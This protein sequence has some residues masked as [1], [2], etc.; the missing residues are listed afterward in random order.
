MRLMRGK[1]LPTAIASVS[2]EAETQFSHEKVMKSGSVFVH[3]EFLKINEKQ[4]PII[5]N[6]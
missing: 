1:T 5:G 6:L 3:S 2:L 4:N